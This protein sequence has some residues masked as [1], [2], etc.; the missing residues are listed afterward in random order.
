[1]PIETYKGQFKRPKFIPPYPK[2]MTIHAY[3]GDF[4]DS[5]ANCRMDNLHEK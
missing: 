4:R 2:S 3:Q 1:M 5:K